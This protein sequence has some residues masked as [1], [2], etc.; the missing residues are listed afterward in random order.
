MVGPPLACTSDRLHV[1]ADGPPDRMRPALRPMLV[2]ARQH[3]LLRNSLFLMATTVVNSAFG[4]L[5]WLAVARLFP[6]STVGLASAV[7][8]VST[9]VSMVAQV[10][11]AA[12]LI[13]AL[14][15]QKNPSDWW[16]AVWTVTAT[17]SSVSVLLSCGVLIVLPI[18][19]HDFSPLT[20][21]AYWLLFIGGSALL[22]VGSV[23]D[24]VFVAQRA[25]GNVL[26]R[27]TAVSSTKAVVVIPLGLLLTKSIFPVLSAWA[28]AALGGLLLGGW[29]LIRKVGAPRPCQLRAVLGRTRQQAS[30][31]LGNQLIG[32]GGSVPPLLFPILVAV[33]LSARQTAYFYT[34]WM[35][36]GVLLVISPSVARS[37]F[38]EGANSPT[39]LRRAARSAGVILGSILLPAMVVFLLAGQLLLSAFG[40]EYPTH[41]IDLLQL[42][43]FSAI[44]DAITNVYVS[45][46]RVENRLQTAMVINVGM[47][48]GTLLLSWLLLPS[49]GIAA[50]GLSWLIMQS[51]GSLFVLVDTIRHGMQVS[52][53][54]HLISK[55]GR[56]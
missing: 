7:I 49:L 42:I 50:V 23:L 56:R 6:P 46:L 41:S 31:M 2:R 11:V 32:L 8:S 38:A 14:P 55:H 33:R 4:Y 37:L 19:S 17:A 13:Q 45:V 15:Q 12:S 28:I 1:A 30:G 36:C 20:S 40:P 53:P 21:P 29:L 5:F 43:V 26:A 9:I 34:T 18:I 54:D 48:V 47:G 51:A 3:T 22:T 44:P 16:L 35:M 27:N 24:S 52:T 25:A 10:G 39:Q